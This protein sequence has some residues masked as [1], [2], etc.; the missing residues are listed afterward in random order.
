MTSPGSLNEQERL[1]ALC[2]YEVLDS[3]PET[4]FDELAKLAAHLCE[5]PTALITFVDE[6]RQWFK[7]RVGF[8]A[9][10]TPREW[11]FCAHA[12][13]QRDLTIVPDTTKDPR[14]AHN[15]LVVGEP[16]I[17]FYAGAPL[18]STD[19]HALGT[20]CVIDY[21]PREMTSAQQ[22]ALRALSRHVMTHLEARRKAGKPPHTRLGRQQAEAADGRIST[23]IEEADHA[24]VALDRN[25]RYTYVS[26]KTAQMFNRQPGDLIGK[27][28]WAEF[29]DRRGQLLYEGYQRSMSTQEF[30][31]LEDYSPPL[32]RWFE[33]RVYPTPEGLSIFFHDVTER[34]QADALLAGQNQVLEMIGRGEPLDAT[35]TALVRF[36]ESQAPKMLCSVLLLDEDGVHVRTG[37][38]PSLPEAYNRAV[39]GQSIGP[40]AGSC[41]TALYRREPVVVEDTTTDPLWAN[42]RALAIA[43]GLRAAWAT[44]IFNASGR[45]LGTF[46]AYYREPGRPPPRHQ[47]LVDIATHLASVAI[48]RQ[49]SEQSLHESRDQLRALADRLQTVREE[50]STHIAREIHDVLGQQLTALKLELTSLKRR[51]SG[52]ADEGLKGSFTEKLNATSQLVDA[53]IQSVQKIATDLR[54]ATL[55]KLGLAAALEREARDFA[56]RS[57]LRFGCDMTPEPLFVNDKTAIGIFRIVQEALTNVARHAQATEVRISLRLQPDGLK[58]EVR[59]DGRGFSQTRTVVG[60]SIGLLGMY[61]RARLLDSRLEI[62]SVPGAGTI[63]N[64][65]VPRR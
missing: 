23:V 49:Q 7:S 5:T 65:H 28:I 9:S 19:G 52:I 38:A 33:N 12:I 3:W 37:A 32:D 59:D 10:E 30:V 29:P 22:T 50:Q 55:D 1:A 61:E 56:R 53:T 44:P 62:N 11:S 13:L 39:D 46:A 2:Q 14:F 8:S 47:A 63:I 43:H 41:G 21:V 51:S 25:W 17:R 27:Q 15:P 20:L 35:L 24:F 18:I 42:Y 54:P 64:L 45:A 40:A 57:G 4:A 16:K 34:K 48:S 6:E 26:A 60:K 36:L 58:V 31:I